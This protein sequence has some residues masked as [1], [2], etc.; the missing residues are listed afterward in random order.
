M[1]VTGATGF[2]GG[3]LVRA[4]QAAGRSVRAL[5]LPGDPGEAELKA[6][7]VETVQGDVRDQGAVN[8]AAD[9]V[10]VV[11]HCAAVVTDWAPGRLFQEVTVGG[12]ENICRAALEA[13]VGRLVAVSTN[14]VF[15]LD[16]AR[17]MDESFPLAPWNEPYPDAKIEAEKVL[18][19]F[20]REHGLPVS[21]VYPCWVYG[22]GDRT[23][24]PLLADAIV[25]REMVFWRRGALV[26]P[27]YIE[28]LMDLMLVLAEDGR[29]VGRGFLIH[30]GEAVTLE[31]LCGVIAR[32]LGVRPPGLHIPYAAAYVA[33][34]VLE[35][36]WKALRIKTRPLLTTYA[37]KDLGSRLR[38][39]IARAERELGW[40]PPAP[41]E[42]GL[43]RTM[44]W[45]RGLDLSRLKQK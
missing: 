40:R 30:D 42:K 34:A 44:E 10:G 20:H 14:D 9:G 36:V 1:L 8:R 27:T 7:G 4:N 29:A 17:V 23:F 3:H 2:I 24:I 11:F 18:W 12:T 38:F 22:P 31:D 39:S 37:V 45:L 35:L 26:W 16:E 32:T 33:A 19:R 21:L 6:L 13:G 28:N 43:A 15:G 41:P 5:V 25:K